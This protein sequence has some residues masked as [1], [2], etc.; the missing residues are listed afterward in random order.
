MSGDAFTAWIPIV[1]AYII[2]VLGFVVLGDITQKV[3]SFRR[4]VLTA[5]F[6]SRMKLMAVS[7]VAMLAGLYL[8]LNGGI[9]SVAEAVWLLAGFGF[10]F[11][12]GFINITYAM[13]R[14]DNGEARFLDQDE[15]APYLNERDEVAVVELGGEARAYPTAWSSRPH[16]I[17]NADDPFGAEDSV[18]TYCGMSH[19][20][21][22]YTPRIGGQRID[23]A[24]AGQMFNNL[25]LYDRGSNQVIQQLLGHFEKDG[26]EG[27]AAPEPMSRQ[28]VRIMPYRSFR[29]L[30]PRG[31]VYFNPP[32]A[33]FRGLLS[34]IFDKLV[35]LMVEDVLRRQYDRGNDKP[36]FPTIPKFDGRLPNK[37]FVYA[38]DISGDRVAYTKEFLIAQNNRVD[39]KIGGEDVAIVHFP[40]LE[41]VDAFKTGG[42]KASGIR[43]DGM[44]AEGNQLERQC[45]LPEVFW[46]VWSYQF[47]DTAL[48]R[49]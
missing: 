41:F 21:I 34:K 24:V 7:A 30:Y 6:R 36:F 40:D 46:M 13:F 10:F 48:N 39:V 2:A 22:A 28:P 1:A 44:T 14:T 8:G 49:M 4:G 45:M 11:F 20:A 9:L 12:S 26:G 19:A 16:V 17:A 31:R 27:E 3:I 29:N 25:L 23:L 37:T 33:P 47:Q 35:R 38:F 15:V 5:V 42:R 43:P 32:W 18:M